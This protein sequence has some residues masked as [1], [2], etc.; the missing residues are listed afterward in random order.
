MKRVYKNKK[1]LALILFIFIIAF[2]GILLLK[3]KETQTSV[4]KNL[5]EDTYTAYVKINPL[6]K[7]SFKGYY[8][9][10]IDKNEKISICGDYTTKIT[11]VELKNSDAKNIYKDLDFGGKSLEDTIVSLITTAHDNNINIENVNITTDW[12]YNIEN[13]KKIVKEKVK[14]NILVESDV[15]FNYQKVIDDNKILDSEKVNSY[16]V[17]FDSNGGE[18]VERQLVLENELVIKPQ[19]PTRKGYTFI[20]WQIGGKAYDFNTKVTSNITLVAKWQ[21]NILK[22]DDST[23]NLNASSGPNKE[24]DNDTLIKQLHAKGLEWDFNTYEEANNEKTKW[25][26]K[27]GFDGEIVVSNYG[28][29]DTA[30][31]LII[32]VNAI[33]CGVDK[34]VNVDWRNKTDDMDDFIYYLYSKGYNCSGSNGYH[35]GKYFIINENNVIEYQ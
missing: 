2:V 34:K 13:I 32:T 35:N 5:K 8:Y 4:K 26:E 29:S 19:N 17:N 25:M 30:Y 27:G 33:A 18:D 16:Y 28:S 24:H 15:N 31:S 10:C 11:T 14:S 9:E 22:E 12:N 3:S 23:D 1:I 7:L 6:I 21:K 20:E